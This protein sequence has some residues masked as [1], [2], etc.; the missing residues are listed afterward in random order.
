M[1]KTVD[2]RDRSSQEVVN[3]W[4]F[5]FSEDAKGIP[6]LS[7]RAKCPHP[8]TW[9]SGAEQPKAHFS[10]SDHHVLVIMSITFT[11]FHKIKGKMC[12]LSAY[13]K[14]SGILIHVILLFHDF[15]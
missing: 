2:Y 6:A 3:L 1:N 8:E 5:V 14:R 7:S 11:G 13:R 4:S 9:F 12:F 10:I 15:E